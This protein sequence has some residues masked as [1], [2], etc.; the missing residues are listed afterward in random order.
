VDRLVNPQDVILGYNFNVFLTDKKVGDP[1]VAA[2]TPTPPG[3]LVKVSETSSGG[4]P[5]FNG[6][7][8]YNIK[9]PAGGYITLQ[10]TCTKL[11]NKSGVEV[12]SIPSIDKQNITIV[13]NSDTKYTNV[14]TVDGLGN[15][16]AKVPYTSEDYVVTDIT[17]SQFGKPISAGAVSPPFTL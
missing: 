6:P 9:K 7:D 10:F 13:N 17:S 15:F 4:L 12:Y 11:I 8:Y 5:N 14:V 1:V 2:T 3:T 16:Q